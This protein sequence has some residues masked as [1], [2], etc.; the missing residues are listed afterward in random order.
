MSLIEEYMQKYFKIY[1]NKYFKN[2]EKAKKY[3]EY[4]WTIQKIFGTMR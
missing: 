1:K 3:I 4:R 2:V